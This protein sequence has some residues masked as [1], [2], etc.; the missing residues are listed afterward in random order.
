LRERSS[1][2]ACVRRFI[3]RHVETLVV[4]EVIKGQLWQDGKLF[5]NTENKDIIVNRI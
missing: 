3:Q 4:K 2:S 5:L 1:S